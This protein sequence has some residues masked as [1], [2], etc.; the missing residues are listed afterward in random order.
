MCDR[1]KVQQMDKLTDGWTD[2]P[3][4]RN[5]RMDLKTSLTEFRRQIRSGNLLVCLFLDVPFD[6]IVSCYLCSFIQILP[7]NS[8]SQK[9]NSCVTDGLTNWQIDTPSCEVVGSGVERSGVTKSRNNYWWILILDC[10]TCTSYNG[11]IF[12]G[13]QIKRHGILQFVI[14][15]EQDILELLQLL[16]VFVADLS[17]YHVVAFVQIARFKL[18][19]HN[20]LKQYEIDV[21]VS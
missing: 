21:L 3:S 20:G 2:I 7:G 6:G 17:L 18:V 14:D 9:L 15:D 8:S 12:V 4:Y 16:L 19:M 11:V 10:Y 5:A 13:K 1:W